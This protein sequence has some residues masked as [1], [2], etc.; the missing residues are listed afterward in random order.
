MSEETTVAAAM[1]GSYVDETYVDGA[2]DRR[3]GEGVVEMIGSDVV[4]WECSLFD[5][6]EGVVEGL[7]NIW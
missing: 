4:V 1:R 6:V 7:V 2:E 5:E 3:V